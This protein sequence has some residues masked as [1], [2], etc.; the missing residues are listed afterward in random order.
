MPSIDDR[1]KDISE[2]RSMME[3]STKFLSLSGLSGI[4][5]GVVGIVAVVVAQL[6]L[7]SAGS[8]SAVPNN[9]R[10]FLIGSV[11]TL[12]AAL[13]LAVFFSVRM[14]RKKNLPVWGGTT[15]SLLVNLFIPL[16]AGG[17]FCFALLFHNIPLLIAPSMLIF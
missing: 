11:M 3:Q 12:V 7:N 10:L 16:V 15:K 1:L 2:I 17:L 5:A 13:S 8:E 14:A 9:A 4:S 6:F